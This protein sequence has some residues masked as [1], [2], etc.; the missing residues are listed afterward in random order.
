MPLSHLD[1]T[2]PE[3]RVQICQDY[4]V[5]ADDCIT[6]YGNRTVISDARHHP[7]TD[8]Y[9]Q[10]SVYNHG[11]DNPSY[12]IVCGAGAARHF[13]QLINQ[14][15]PRSF[16]PFVEE[17]EPVNQAQGHD[18]VPQNE[19]NVQWNPIRRQ[20][21]NAVQLFIIRYQHSLKPGTPIFRISQELSQRDIQNVPRFELCSG[22][23]SIVL[24]F[25]TSMPEII[26][27]LQRHRQ[28][29]NFNFT[30]LEY[31]MVNTFHL[32]YIIFYDDALPE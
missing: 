19:N 26:E 10:F 1:C 16:N 12:V 2:S 25:N 15:L 23:S 9:Y 13:C 18:N 29:R 11:A 14:P 22:F 17:H 21:Y 7:I 27:D 20:L 6:I 31:Y 24:A 28:V 30:E 3:R 8:R 4:D 32:P 5:H